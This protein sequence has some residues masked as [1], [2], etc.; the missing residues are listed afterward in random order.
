[1]SSGATLSSGA[2]K[3]PGERAAAASPR[4]GWPRLAGDVA[5]A[6]FL[7]AGALRTYLLAL[8]GNFVRSAL[9]AEDVVRGEPPWR[10]FQSRVLGPYLVHALSVASH[11][12]A[13]IVYSFVTL[14]LLFLAGILILRF[15]YLLGD[16]AR[17]PFGMLF[18]FEALLLILLPCIWLYVWDGIALVLFLVFNF[19]VLRRAG[20]GAFAGLF[21]VAI[22]NHEI[23][24]WIAAWLVLDAVVRWR[25]ARG[26]ARGRAFDRGAFAL[27]L[28]MLAGGIGLVELLRRALLVREVPPEGADALASHGGLVHFTLARNWDAIVHSF[29]LAP[30]ADLQFVVPMYLA[31]VLVVAYR[32]ARIDWPRFGALAVVTAGMVM[33]ALCFGLILETRVLLPLVPFVAMNGLAVLRGRAAT[34]PSR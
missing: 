10:V 7:A 27:G 18:T 8:P 1:M 2:R 28:T 15:G 4:P 20:R 34:A 33:S 5:L 9:V 30:Q 23:S 3:A 24:L 29:T 25:A 26:T 11:T 12:P 17:L 14:A 22:L 31:L 6:L 16:P 21:G 32:L 19:L 13:P